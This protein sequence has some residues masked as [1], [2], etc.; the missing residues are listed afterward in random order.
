[1]SDSMGKKQPLGGGMDQDLTRTPASKWQ[2]G[3]HVQAG[4]LDSSEVIQGGYGCQ[5]LG[6]WCLPII[7][8]SIPVCF[9]KNA[10]W[11]M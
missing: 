4:P 1:V 9:L 2:E 6:G 7:A 3:Y 5:Q 8:C 11:C 10:A